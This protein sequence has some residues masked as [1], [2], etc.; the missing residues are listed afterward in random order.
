MASVVGCISCGHPVEKWNKTFG[1]SMYD[2][3]YSV[4]QTSDGGY[5][6][7]GDTASYGAIGSD[8]LLIKTDSGGNEQ[9]NKTFGGSYKDYGRCVQQTSDNGYVILGYTRSHGTT[10]SYDVWLIKT[11]SSGNQQWNKTFGGPKTDY[12]YSVRQTADGGYIIAGDTS[13]YGAGRSDVWLIKTDS[14]GNEQWNKT[15]GGPDHDR[16][17]CV[18][19]TSDGGYVVAGETSSYGIRLNDMWLIKTDSSG[20]EEWTRTFG[21]EGGDGAFCVQQTND[22]GYV[23]AGWTGSDPSGGVLLI[24]TDSSGEEL[25]NRAFGRSGPDFG[26]CV[27][28]TSDAGYIIAGQAN[29]FGG[30]EPTGSEP[31]QDV[32]PEALLIK[33]DSNGNEQWKK[34]Y[35][36]SDD[37]WG[38]CVQQT[39]DGGFIVAGWLG[40]SAW[41]IKTDV[42]GNTD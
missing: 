6:L 34:M 32:S 33:T 2:K 42:R 3:A 27:E 8:I 26:Y 10:D 38:R 31:Q 4:Q 5:I 41:L 16:G 39:C 29:A 1:G 17:R 18:Q 23:I 28:Q 20:N 19:R 14:N 30:G 12:G 24:K 11:D 22:G 35:G 13:S 21:G 9:W 7:A 15:F 36:G 37:G 40:G 25:W